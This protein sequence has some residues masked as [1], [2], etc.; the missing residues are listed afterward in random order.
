MDLLQAINSELLVRNSISE[1]TA[2]VLKGIM[3]PQWHSRGIAE[4]LLDYPSLR[5]ELIEEAKKKKISEVSVSLKSATGRTK[6]F[7]DFSQDSVA[8]LVINEH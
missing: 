7:W 6:P 4:T 8:V 3:V 1:Q 5:E 2:E